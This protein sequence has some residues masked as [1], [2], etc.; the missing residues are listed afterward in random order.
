MS[1]LV[2]TSALLA[3]LDADDESHSAAGETWVRL[4]ERSEDIYCTSYILVESF[5]LVQN[6]LG[7]PAVR[8]LV[9][10]VLPVLRVHWV[11]PEEHRAAV[12]AL[13]TAGRR[14]LSLVDCVSFE[15]MRRSGVT[16]A[17]AFDVILRSRA[18]GC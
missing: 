18:S 11:S 2:D 16:S 14:N 1:V 17:F 9:E 10:D 8:V 15:S 3:V 7:I 6:R 12:S 4:L 5:A 13:L